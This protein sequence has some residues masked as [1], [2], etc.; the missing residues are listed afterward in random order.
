M[1][2]LGIR[3]STYWLSGSVWGQAHGWQ[4]SGVPAV[5]SPKKPGRHCSQ[6]SP[7]VLCRQLWKEK[8]V[9]RALTVRKPKCYTNEMLHTVQMP[10]S[11]WHESEWPLQSQSSQ[12][13]R[14]SP[15]PVRVYPGAQSWN[16][17]H[18]IEKTNM[19]LKDFTLGQH[20][21][22]IALASNKSKPGRRV[23]GIRGGSGT[24]PPPGPEPS[25]CSSAQPPPCWCQRY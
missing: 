11:G 17:Q 16:R 24:V 18:V 25:R 4:S 19:N 3:A 14:Y 12:W 8:H 13:P 2:G 6:S 5:G 22:I 20:I 1:W 23:P 10:V 21:V 7:W 9:L 15:P